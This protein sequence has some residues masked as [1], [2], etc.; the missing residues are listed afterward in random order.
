[1]DETKRETVELIF[2]LIG[3]QG[4][5]MRGAI[6]YLNNN[7]I[8]KD[9]KPWKGGTLWDLIYNPLYMGNY[10]FIGEVT[11]IEGIVSKELY[12]KTILQIKGN[13]LR[14]NKGIVN[15]NPLKGLLKCPCGSNMSIAMRLKGQ[16]YYYC[17][18]KTN[19]DLINYHC[20]NLGIHV[21]HLNKIVW[22]FTKA[23]LNKDDFE[24]KTVSATKEIEK[25]I[26]I[27]KKKSDYLF[28]EMEKLNTEIEVAT[29]NLM[30]VT[31]DSIFKLIND[32]ISDL[33]KRKT[34]YKNTFEKVNATISKLKVKLNN[35]DYKVDKLLLDSLTDEEKNVIYLKYIDKV[36]YYSLGYFKGVIHILYNNGIQYYALTTSKPHKQAYELPQSFDFNTMNRKVVVPVQIF[37]DSPFEIPRTEMRE[38]YFEEF[39]A[40]YRLEDFKMNLQD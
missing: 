10:T 32:N 38:Y 8:L 27:K 13:H 5:T 6:T 37:E 30:K 23:F 14:K 4:Y 31:D 12:E 26:E 22:K 24:L 16:K 2:D 9:G 18:N 11:K 35:Y 15:F 1:M 33:V 25:E 29:K 28:L 7:G 40:D 36:T 39:I 21:A 20:S 17:I 3:N 19:R 34:D